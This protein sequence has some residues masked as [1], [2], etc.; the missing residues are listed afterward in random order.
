MARRELKLNMA[1][2]RRSMLEQ[3]SPSQNEPGRELFEACRNGDL[4]KVKKLVTTQNVNSK[5][6]AGRKSSP[7]HFAAGKKRFCFHSRSIDFQY[8]NQ[9][10]G[11]FN[12]H[13]HCLQ[14]YIAFLSTDI[15]CFI[16]MW[17]ILVFCFVFNK[18]TGYI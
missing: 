11:R 8:T 13:A 17:D 6:T 15:E 9:L 1:T 2:S 16:H 4:N 10:K 5:D 18:F 7:L 14:L 3:N 12:H